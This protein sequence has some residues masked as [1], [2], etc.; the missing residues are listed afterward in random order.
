MELSRLIFY[1]IYKT[2]KQNE[3]IFLGK[4]NVSAKCS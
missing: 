2:T 1:E 4:T 3:K